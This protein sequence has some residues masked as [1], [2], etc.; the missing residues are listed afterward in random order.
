MSLRNSTDQPR[1]ARGFSRL[2]PRLLLSISLALDANAHAEPLKLE[3]ALIEAA[4]KHPSVQ[5]RRS[6]RQAA[7]QRLDAAEW[8][9]YPSLSAQHGTNQTGQRYTTARIDQPLWSGGAITAQIDSARAGVTG[10]ESSVT[11]AQQEIMGRVAVSF[12][13]LG[14]ITA[15][16]LA[17]SNNVI[18]HERLAALIARR[19]ASE[20]SP[21]S[22]GVLAQG[23]LSQAR[24]E[25]NQ[26]TALAARA[27][28]ELTNALDRPVE[29][30]VLPREPT[31]TYPALSAVID[32]AL[33]YSPTLRRL[34]AEAEAAAAEV[35]VRRGAT[36]PRI[37]ARYERTYG[38]ERV[39]AE[40]F[41][42]AVEYQTGA[43]LAS[44]ASIREAKA[45]REAAQQMRETARRNLLDSVSADWAD[46]ESLRR[47]AQELAA[48]VESTTAFYDSAVRQYAVGRKSWI[49]VLNA[50]REATQARYALADA[51]WGALRATL[52]LQFAT[53]ELT[54]KNL[55]PGTG[56]PEQH[57]Q[58]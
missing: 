12:T 21:A 15:R 2:F 13:D 5:T 17:A 7:A 54:V 29:D 48:Q 30:V 35:A 1:Q 46:R 16:S 11:E 43:G 53:G 33:A 4:S 41:F 57:A 44:L 8:G 52:R 58:H 47:Q 20:V 3:E 9:R 50:Q 27:R 14:R 19:V 6:D 32:A 23:R 38:D 37:I 22:D 18:E 45:K 26:L 28:A 42:V 49:D 55:T 56:R 34:E 10:A 36:R 25:M 51:Q 31:I 40:R 39:R 24:A